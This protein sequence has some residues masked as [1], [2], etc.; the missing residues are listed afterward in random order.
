MGL[1]NVEELD[2]CPLTPE[3]AA[4]KLFRTGG[5]LYK[6]NS[7]NSKFEPHKCHS[8][9]TESRLPKTLYESEWLNNRTGRTRYSGPFRMKDSAR[10][11]P[12]DSRTIKRTK[13]TRE[14]EWTFVNMYETKVE[15]KTISPED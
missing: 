8:A 12:P 13:A 11:P 4:R 15:W 3:C 5:K 2:H 10:K 14:K 7:Q 1:P 9:G 6:Y